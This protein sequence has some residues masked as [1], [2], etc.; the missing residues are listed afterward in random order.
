MTNEIHKRRNFFISYHHKSNFHF[1]K[2]LRNRLNDG[3]LKDYGFKE[4]DLAENSKFAIAKII[5]YRIWASSVTVVLVGEQT[6]MS[7]W[8][9]WEI[10]YSLQNLKA[11][12]PAKRRFKPKGLLALF[13]PGSNHTIPQRLQGNLNS[14]YAIQLNWENLDKEFYTSL[15]KAAQNRTMTHL[16]QSQ[17]KPRINP[18]DTW[19]KLKNLF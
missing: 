14:G 12:G 4:L 9:D 19:G 5:Q 17:N 18:Q 3:H 2:E 11:K 8:V 16:I 13:L 6:G 10:W 15:E 7:K 1:L